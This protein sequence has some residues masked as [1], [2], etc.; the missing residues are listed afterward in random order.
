MLLFFKKEVLSCFILTAGAQRGGAVALLAEPGLRAAWAGA[1][2]GAAEIRDRVGAGDEG[3]VFGLFDCRA[4]RGAG[5]GGIDVTGVAFD[6]A[7]RGEV[8]G[9]GVAGTERM[10]LRHRFTLRRGHFGQ[11][12]RRR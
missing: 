6:A 4:Q 9:A 8:R 10:N 2:G 7:D 3:A 12:W 11:G 5:I 1:D